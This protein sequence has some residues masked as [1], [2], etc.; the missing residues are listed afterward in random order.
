MPYTAGESLVKPSAMEIARIMCSDVVTN[1]LAMVVLQTTP[2]S[3]AIKNSWP[4]F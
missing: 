3:G 1:K 4:I 2:S